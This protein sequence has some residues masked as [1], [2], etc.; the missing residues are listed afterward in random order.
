MTWI[1]AVLYF[2]FF[3]IA[4]YPHSSESKAFKM[5]GW[6]QGTSWHI[7]YYAGDSLVRKMQIDSLFN[8]LDSSLS[9]YKPYSLI[10]NFNASA[11]GIDADIH[12]SAVVESALDAW[13]QSDGLF[14]ITI[15]PLV[16]AWGFSSKPVK[17][18]P[19]SGEVRKMLHCVGTDKIK[20]EGRRLIKAKPC[21]TIDVDGIA[22]GYSVDVVAGFLE[23]RKVKSYIVELGGEIRVKG[24]K[25]P[26]NERMKIGIEAPGDY[27]GRPSVIQK[28]IALE[29]GAVTTSGNYRRYHESNGE[30]FSHTIDP[31]TGYPTK[32][33]LIS[34]TVF[35]G[36]AIT[37]DAYDNV[38]MTLGLEK[39]LAFVEKRKDI[40]AYFIYK[41]K[42]GTIADTASSRFYELLSLDLE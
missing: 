31:R 16:Q 15:H 1:L 11:N 26:A 36:D 42:E 39:A 38:L 7:T 8:R 17:H 33:N 32:N 24:R 23:S 9:I 10:S 19:D 12:L 35:A 28:I 29:N 6:A 21:V 22:Q 5:S 18:Y 20:L 27:N 41:N 30:K 37:A 2:L 4:P 3:A 40:A 34:V 13:Q 14:D 25:Q